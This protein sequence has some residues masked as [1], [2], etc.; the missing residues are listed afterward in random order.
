MKISSFPR[1]LISVIAVLLI[2]GCNQNKDQ[3][4]LPN[5]VI[6][7]ADDMGYGDPGCY[8]SQIPTP[9]IDQM[10]AEGV[11]FTDFYVAQAV[12]GASRAALLTGCYPNRVGVYGAPGPNATTGIHPDEVTIAELLKQKDYATA[13]YGKWHLG[14]LKP[15]LP[16]HNG[17]DEYFGTPYSNDMWPKHPDYFLF[18]KEVAARKRGYPPLPLIAG[19]TVYKSGLT[20]ED[21]ALFTK[22]FTECAVDFIK[23]NQDQPF[24]V[25]LAHPMPHVP[26]FA[27]EDFQG[28]SGQ[29][30]FGDV[31]M[32]IDWSVGQINKTLEELGL[33]DN[34]LVIFTSDNGPWLSYG[35]HAGS[36]GPLREGKGTAWDGGMREPCVMKW[37]GKIPAGSICAEPAMTIDVLPTIAHLTGTALPEHTID[38]LNIWPLISGVEGAKS[39]QEAYYFFWLN[40][41][42]A[43]RSG[44]WKMHFPHWYRT[45]NGMETGKDGMPGNYRQDSTGFVLYNLR[46]D[47]GET[48]DLSAEYPEKLEELRELG[49]KIKKELGHG[50]EKGIGVREIGK[51]EDF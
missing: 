30:V 29:G 15:F 6:I 33:D 31:I 17:F 42:N 50:K 39:P 44:D 28:K 46:D 23:R 34:T 25:Y 19:D 43:V 14:H 13:M 11:R 4:E 2:S 9:N 20:E 10:A 7:F 1:L 26:I 40:N 41:L 36:A 35:N 37:K 49:E 22:Q 18:P 8:G 12:C 24:F 21:Q 16:V 32:E 51:I 5:I 48:T 45:M 38:G 3:S 47:I 27:S